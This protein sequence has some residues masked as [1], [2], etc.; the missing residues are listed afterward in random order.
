MPAEQS[1]A[2]QRDIWGPI[3]QW[4]REET[5]LNEWLTDNEEGILLN[6]DPTIYDLWMAATQ[7]QGFNIKTILMQMYKDSQDY[8]T[9]KARVEI[10]FKVRTPGG[11]KT[12]KYDNHQSMSRDITFLALIFSTRGSTWD[13]IIDKSVPELKDVLEWLKDKYQIDTTVHAAGKSLPPNV[14]TLPR[15]AGCMPLKMCEL[16]VLNYGKRYCTLEQ[17]GLNADLGINN[18][19]LSPFF[20]CAIPISWCFAGRAPHIFNFL[21]H[22]YLDNT[23]HKKERDYTSLESMFTYYAAAFRTPGVP[24]ASRIKYITNCGWKKQGS[25]SFKEEIIVLIEAANVLLRAL[26]PDD[27]QLEVVIDDLKNLVD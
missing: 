10:E 22:V 23:I 5:V 2:S 6:N 24:G 26:R 14:V 27:P 7:Y 25:N 11:E 1:L 21:V 16:L 15:I 20:N 9:D 4:I 17:I 13:K 3:F 8:I 12:F 18:A 19:V